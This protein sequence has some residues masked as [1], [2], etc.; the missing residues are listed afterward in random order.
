MRKS[1]FI[2]LFLV[3]V[4][5]MSC[6]VIA[7]VSTTSAA[8]GDV[9]YFDNS[10]TNFSEVYC[11]MYNNYG[12]NAQFP[13]EA[14]ENVS[15]DIWSYT[16]SGNWNKIV[17]TD[18][19]TQS[20][21][22]SYSGDGQ[23]AK[24]DS[25]EEDF[26]VSWTAYAE[27]E[28]KAKAEKKTKL[29]TG[30]GGTVYCQ[31]D[32]D[33]SSVCVYM[34]NSDQDKL[35]EWPGKPMTDLGDG[36]WEFNYDKSYAN[37]IFNANGAPQTSD[38][39]F[40]GSGKIYNNKTKGWED[41]SSSPVKITSLNTDVESPSY[42]NS[43]VLISATAKSSA[44]ALTYKFTAKDSSGGGAILS[45]G[46]ASSVTWIPTKAGNYTITVDVSDTAGNTNSRSIS[47]EIRDASNLVEPFISAFSNSLGTVR[48]IKK[49]TNITFTTGAIGGKTG[50]NLLFYKFIITDPD[51]NDN[52]P[53]YTLSNAYSYKPT[54]LGTYT[55]KAYVQNSA[56]DTVDRTYTYTC[57]ADIPADDKDIQP[58]VAPYTPTTPVTPTTPQQPTTTPPNIDTTPIVTVPN[59]SL[60]D[61]NR[62][63]SINIKDATLIQKHLAN[64]ETLNSEQQKL[65]DTNKDG[66]VSVKDATQIQ[67][68][69]AKMIT[70]F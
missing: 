32:A 29:K 21:E 15:G 37:I 28:T 58:T 20:A 55:V 65:A 22:L 18:G 4:M 39:T 50:T 23:I 43:S 67:K 25:S 63:G 31:N 17:F 19:E 34:W 47:F 11:Y 26:T 51:G 40:P 59:P 54:K 70:S 3:A 62:D 41:Y 38:M 42:T 35:A 53:Y 16:V 45:N 60:G 1:K 68:Y 7:G 10:V 48:Y 24:P 9:I 5:V 36:V 69:V 6:M 44:G 52:V 64:L 57:A 30:A 8:A 14:M 49:D 61:V 13:G 2:S 27:A 46:S 56:N 66:Y 33:W 12:S